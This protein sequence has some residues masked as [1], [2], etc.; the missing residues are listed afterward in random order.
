[1]EDHSYTRTYEKRARRE[2]T[3]VLALNTQGR[4]G[5]CRK[6]HIMLKPYESKTGYG[7]RLVMKIQRYIPA[8]K[9][10]NEQVNHLLHHSQN[11]NTRLILKTSWRWYSSPATSDLRRG[12]DLE[13]GGLHQAGMSTE[14]MRFFYKE[15]RS[16]AMAI[17]L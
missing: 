15:V 12:E 9:C 11:Q 1:M 7:A 8:N 5:P 4:A 17:P 2:K 3:W 10:D 13:I 6:D 16:Q 14:Q